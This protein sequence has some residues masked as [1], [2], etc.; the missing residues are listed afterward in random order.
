MNILV[1]FLADD[2]WASEENKTGFLI[3]GVDIIESIIF[4]RTTNFLAHGDNEYYKTKIWLMRLCEKTQ[5]NRNMWKFWWMIKILCL[6]YP[7]PM[8]KLENQNIN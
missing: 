6:G 2:V 5:Q 3:V 7:P 1:K 8:E 4:E